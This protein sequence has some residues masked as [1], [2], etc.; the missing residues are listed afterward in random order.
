M[1]INNS[2]DALR[3]GEVDAEGAI[4]HAAVHGWY[5]GHIEGEDLCP[6]CTHRG[7]MEL[8]RQLSGPLGWLGRYSRSVAGDKPVTPKP[9]PG[10]TTIVFKEP[11]CRPGT[12]EAHRHGCQCRF[13]SNLAAS[14]IAPKEEG[15][16]YVVV[17]K[18]CPLHVII[19]GPPP[20]SESESE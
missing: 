6:G 13:E 12:P 4:A 18:D 14:M 3:A 20:K 16:E 19:D 8:R 11:Y 7:D 15:M 9:E 17:H 1:I 5:E 2:I 10:T